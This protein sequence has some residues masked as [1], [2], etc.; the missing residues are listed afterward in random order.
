MRFTQG[1]IRIDNINVCI[2][3]YEDTN[4]I[5]TCI[6]PMGYRLENRG[7]PG[8]DDLGIRELCPDIEIDGKSL[9][10]LLT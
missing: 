5:V 10:N 6:D 2:E 1:V 4:S 9:S 3:V 7:Y 8:A